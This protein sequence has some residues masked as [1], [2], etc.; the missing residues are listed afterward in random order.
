[1]LL[2]STEG[3]CV[4]LLD[5]RRTASVYGCCGNKREGKSLVVSATKLFLSCE[6]SQRRGG[7][8]PLTD[9]CPR[10]L[11][12]VLWGLDKW[13]LLT[14]GIPQVMSNLLC[15]FGR[16]VSVISGFVIEQNRAMTL[17]V[18]KHKQNICSR[19]CGATSK[20]LCLKCWGLQMFG[21]HRQ[22]HSSSWD[23]NGNQ[24]MEWWRFLLGRKITS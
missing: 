9:L 2:P 20:R 12:S 17:S 3:V 21:I 6:I 14:R 19:A 7:K 15:H 4:P 1:M 23:W 13:W 22:L 8:K 11:N 10:Q 24:S 18:N 5:T 16:Y